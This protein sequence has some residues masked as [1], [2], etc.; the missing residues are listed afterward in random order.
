[1]G[2]RIDK[3]DNLFSKFIRTRDKWTCRRCGKYLQPPTSGLHN[4]H[5]VGRGSWNS[6]YDEE[7]CDALCY[8]CHQVWGGDGRDD[9]KAFKIKQLG[10][11]RFNAL[12]RR[13]NEYVNKRKLRE[14][15]WEEYKE[16]LKALE[17]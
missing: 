7:N 11:K 1:M 13:S 14:R 12:I 8:G 4:S 3:Y 15:V 5:Y 16:K 6:R 10:K 17:I 9:Y 2:V